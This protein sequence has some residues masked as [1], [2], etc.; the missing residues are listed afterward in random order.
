MVVEV[1]ILVSMEVLATPPFS[2]WKRGMSL[3]LSEVG[4]VMVGKLLPKVVIKGSVA[5]N[6]LAMEELL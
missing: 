1:L 3:L 6:T 2:V 4:M 5:L